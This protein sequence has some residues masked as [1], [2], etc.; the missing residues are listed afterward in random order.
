MDLIIQ[1][2]FQV[3]L[4]LSPV[5]ILLGVLF[6]LCY[7]V[8]KVENYKVENAILFAIVI[9]IVLMIILLIIL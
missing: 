5:F 3:V 8:T 9:D 7:K 6:F 2:F 4:Q 1:Y